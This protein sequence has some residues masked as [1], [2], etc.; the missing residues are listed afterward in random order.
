M[1]D[2]PLGS[3][4]SQ[5]KERNRSIRVRVRYKGATLLALK[6]GKVPVSQGMWAASSGWKRQ[7]N[8][9]SLRALTRN[10]AVLTPW[11]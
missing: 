6:M 7:G 9:L 2:Y 8:G 11:S 5:R 1:G 3:I 10:T 4:Y